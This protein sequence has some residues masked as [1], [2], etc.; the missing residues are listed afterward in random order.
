MKPLYVIIELLFFLCFMFEIPIYFTWSG[1]RG[2]AVLLWSSEKFCAPRFLHLHDIMAEFN[3]FLV[4][5]S[6]KI[7][8]VLIIH[9]VAF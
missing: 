2:N 9:M 4:N 6:F 8:N 1:E 5:L 3:N 7:M